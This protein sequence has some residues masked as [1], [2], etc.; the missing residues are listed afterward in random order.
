MIRNLFKKSPLK[1]WVIKQID[2]EAL[3]LC[4]QEILESPAKPK[5]VREAL[6]FERYEGAVR[7]GERGIVLNT[8]RIAAVAPLH[9]FRLVEGGREAEWQGRSWAVSQVPQRCWIYGGHLITDKT[10]Y[11]TPMHWPVRKM[12]R[13]LA[14]TSIV[15]SL[16]RAMSCS[17]PSMPWKT[18]CIIPRRRPRKCRNI[19]RNLVRGSGKNGSWGQLSEP[20][21]E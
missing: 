2:H 6:Y 3:H 8:R 9:R 13:A 19:A 10:Q 17:D 20:P 1:A 11:Q 15:T 14:N 16:R 21:E 12:S 7:M 4:S 5:L 18:P